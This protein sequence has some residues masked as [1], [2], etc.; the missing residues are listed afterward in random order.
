MGKKKS[1]ERLLN[2]RK[3]AVVGASN[4]EFKVGG[5]VFK[6]LLDS[7]RRLF[8]VNP[9]ETAIQGHKTYPDIQS[10]PKDIDLAVI[11]ISAAAAVEAVK[12]CIER[13]IPNYII[14]AGG[15][16]EIRGQG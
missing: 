5:I 14:V 13:Q 1:L 7:R 2:P 9:K 15:F 3:I 6:R 4:S 16:G 11:T 8:P 10:L 12:Q